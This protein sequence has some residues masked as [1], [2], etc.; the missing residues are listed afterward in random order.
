MVS[1]YQSREFGLGLGSKLTPSITAQINIAR[2]NT[3]YVSKEDAI[4]I[5][6]TDIKKDLKDDPT[7][8]YFHAGISNEGYWNTSHA[9][10]QLEDVTVC[11]K[12][13]YPNFDV[14]HLYDQSA[15]HTKIRGD[16]LNVNC[17]NVAPRGGG[18]GGAVHKMRST[19]IPDIG[20]Y[21]TNFKVG[22]ERPRSILPR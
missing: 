3:K 7:L 18:G 12:V 10:V 20:E 22:G 9:K 16:G 15:G 11:L 14:A 19:I 2:S 4:L 17:M 6:G 13:L 1:G 5:H 8:R 21:L